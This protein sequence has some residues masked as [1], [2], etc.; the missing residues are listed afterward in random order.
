[1][2]REV[3]L[4]V[5]NQVIQLDKFVEGFVY[6]ISRGMLASLEGTGDIQTAEIFMDGESIRVVVNNNEIPVNVFVT[7]I[8]RSTITGMISPLKGVNEIGKL[9]LIF[10]NNP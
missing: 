5:N 4:M 7:K 9:H 3:K 1:M 8:L 6:H 10:K 2:A